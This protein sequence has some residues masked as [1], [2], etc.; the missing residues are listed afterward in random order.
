MSYSIKDKAWCELAGAM[1]QEFHQALED[2]CDLYI[3]N[4]GHDKEY[5]TEFTLEDDMIHI[6]TEISHCSCCS[7]DYDSHAIPVSYLWDSNWVEKEKEKIKVRERIEQEMK[8]ANK[9]ERERKAEEARRAQYEKL[10]EE[11]ENVE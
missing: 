5:V 8:A 3:A 10:K 9:L 6:S 2:L 4:F 11:F 7:P 1:Y